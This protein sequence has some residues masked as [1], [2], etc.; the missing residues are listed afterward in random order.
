MFA[1]CNNNPVNASDATGE[2]LIPLLTGR[3][4]HNEVARRVYDADVNWNRVAVT[5][6]VAIGAALVSGLLS[7]IGAMGGILAYG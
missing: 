1:Y 2:R 3:A 4:I 5:A 7:G 6:V